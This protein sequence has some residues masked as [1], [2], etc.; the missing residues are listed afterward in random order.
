MTPVVD[1]FRMIIAENASLPEILPY[2]GGVVLAIII[3][4]TLAIKLFRWE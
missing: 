3:V 4:Y 2:V 1:G